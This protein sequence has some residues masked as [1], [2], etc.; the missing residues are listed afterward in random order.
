MQ[1]APKNKLDSEK[2]W[3]ELD[4]E[5]VKHFFNLCASRADGL[6]QMANTASTEF[7]KYLFAANSGAAAGLFLLLRSSGGEYWYLLAF[8][9]FI[10]GTF[11]VGTAHFVYAGWA[12]K[13]SLGWTAD[14]NALMRSEITIGEVDRRNRERQNQF[15]RKLSWYGLVLSFVM[16]IAGG[17]I[18]GVPFWSKTNVQ[19]PA[20]PAGIQISHTQS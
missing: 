13:L 9:L 3:N 17:V 1:E 19:P 14:F 6:D 11:C 16:L 18:A 20:S 2:T 5:K 15:R 8:S 7:S 12:G 10:F 4:D